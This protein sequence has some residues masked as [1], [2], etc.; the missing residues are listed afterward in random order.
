MTGIVAVIAGIGLSAAAG[1]RVFIPM[2]ALSIA[3]KTGVIELS[4]SF[5]WLASWPALIGLI[6]ATLAE[7][8]AYYIPWVDNML[9]SIATPTALLAGTFISAAVLPEMNDGLKW[10]LAAIMGGA[11]AGV[12]QAGTVLTR[13]TS[14]ATTGGIA[15]P[16]VSTVEAGTSLVTA[17]LA[18]V[19]P[20]LIGIIVLCVVIWLSVKLFKRFRRRPGLHPAA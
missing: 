13:G 17:I 6:T 9:D 12:V 20:I 2:L 7:I 3:G 16:I 18:L 5:Q 10:T 19:I 11:P 15:N 1:F 8:A 4:E 14:T